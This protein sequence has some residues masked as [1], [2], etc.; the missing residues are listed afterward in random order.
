MRLK[1]VAATVALAAA[2]AAAGL[3]APASADPLIPG[4]TG[5]GASGDKQ[6]G[7]AVVGALA[8]GLLGNSLSGHNRTTG[9]VL[10]TAVGAAAGSAVGCQ[11]Q[12]NDEQ[13]AQA[14]EASQA[15]E[16]APPP[17]DDRPDRYPLGRGVLPADYHR[18]DGGLVVT[19]SAALRASPDSRSRRLGML[20]RGE[21][22]DAM[23]EVRGTDWLL[24]GRNGVGVGYV[25]RANARPDS[26]RYADRY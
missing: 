12:H 23:A 10:G 3:A 14:A 6:A 11:M 24:V 7:G 15:A 2:T 1:M 18:L 21:R 16:A 22:F 19:H 26:D 17:R 25:Q 9:T 13:R 8:G 5:C 4:V 20:H